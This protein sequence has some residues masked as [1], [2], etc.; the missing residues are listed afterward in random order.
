M[1]NGVGVR[2]SE[3]WPEQMRR[4]LGGDGWRVK[5]VEGTGLSETSVGRETR[6][7]LEALGS[8]ICGGGGSSEWEWLARGAMFYT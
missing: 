5:A 8:Y 3:C 2:E 6:N 1:Q 4:E 7:H